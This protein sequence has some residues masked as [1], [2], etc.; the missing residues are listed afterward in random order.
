MDTDTR[1]ALAM[2]HVGLVRS[3]V[4]RFPRDLWEDLDQAG[5]LGLLEAIDR[6]DPSRGFRFSTYAY[7]WVRKRIVLAAK[8]EFGCVVSLDEALENEDTR[9]EFVADES[10]VNAEAA[11]EHADDLA[12]LA[13]ALEGLDERSRTIVHGRYWDGLQ[14]KEVATKVGLAGSS[15]RNHNLPKILA[16]LRETFQ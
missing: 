10:A 8:N 15:V 11:L 6:F 16:K 4:R 13:S 9:H 1:N 14:H 2:Q 3:F 5:M 7:F 12:Q